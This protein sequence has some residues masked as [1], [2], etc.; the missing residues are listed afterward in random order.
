MREGQAV[1]KALGLLEEM[2]QK[3]LEPKVITYNA[4]ISACDYA[5]FFVLP[6]LFRVF[7][8]Y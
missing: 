1:G 3:G 4:T 2:R 7:F 6:Y 5:G 8:R